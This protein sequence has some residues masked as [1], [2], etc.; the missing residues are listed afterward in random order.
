MS[1]DLI[2]RFFQATGLT[3]TWE[4]GMEIYRRDC[5]NDVPALITALDDPL[6]ARR[7]AAVYALG[8]SRRDGRAVSP[9]IRVLSN[10]E[11]AIEVRAQAAECLGLM[12]KRKAIRP[13][14]E[15]SV[16]ESAELRFWCVF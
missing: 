7:C 12:R 4:A 11:E 2:E 16:H 1:D 9:L 13:L 6:E 15:S 3:D 14:I 8:F 5:P 10:R